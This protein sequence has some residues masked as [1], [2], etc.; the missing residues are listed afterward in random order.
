MS[1]NND[2]D[3]THPDAFTTSDRR[4]RR[5]SDAAQHASRALNGNLAT[6]DRLQHLIS[7]F[8][9]LTEVGAGPEM[10]GQ[11]LATLE[12]LRGSLNLAMNPHLIHGARV[13]HDSCFI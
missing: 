8:D 7:A 2:F 9:I 6:P 1:P 3:P 10:I 11:S 13:D 4:C 5:L 12:S